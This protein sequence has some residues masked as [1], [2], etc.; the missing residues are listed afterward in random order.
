MFKSISNSFST[1][2]NTQSPRTRLIVAIVGILSVVMFLYWFFVRFVGKNMSSGKSFKDTSNSTQTTQNSTQN[3][4]SSTSANFK[5]TPQL[6]AS[7]LMVALEYTWAFGLVCGNPDNICYRLSSLLNQ[8][9]D[10]IRAVGKA[11]STTS[12]MTLSQAIQNNPCEC[13]ASCWTCRTTKYPANKA[14]IIS[15]LQQFGY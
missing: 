7:E 12:T 9:D 3:S 14:S 10:Y 2:Y 6:F 15:K 13:L 4:S 11:Y 8:S 5:D 1:W